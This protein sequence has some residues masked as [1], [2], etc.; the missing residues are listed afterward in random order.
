MN[1]LVKVY[2]TLFTLLM[3]STGVWAQENITYLNYVGG[4]FVSATTPDPAKKITSESNDLSGW[5][6]VEGEVTIN[7]TLDLGG[8]TEIILCDG[9][10]L[11]IHTSIGNGIDLNGHN[12]TIYAQSSGSHKGKLIINSSGYGIEGYANVTIN[13]GNIS[14]NSEGYGISCEN[15]TVNGGAITVVYSGGDGIHANYYVTI[16]GGKIYIENSLYGISGNAGVEINGG[17]V[18]AWGD[19]IG[20]AG[21]YS[22]HD[23]NLGWTNASDYILAN[24]Y[25]GVDYLSTQDGKG[26]NIQ[27]GGTLAGNTNL[28]ADQKNAI[29]YNKLTPNTTTLSYDINVSVGITGGTIEVDKTKAFAGE[30]VAITITPETGKMLTSLT[31]NDGTNTYTIGTN[32]TD[33]KRQAND[34]VITMPNKNVT[35]T[36]TF[37]TIVAKIGT[38]EYA[39]LDDAF[40]AVG[41]GET[42]DIFA[43]TDESA[44][45]HTPAYWNLDFV[46]DLHGHDVKFGHISNSG[47][48]LTIKSTETGGKFLYSSLYDNNG[49]ITIDNVTMTCTG[50]ISSISNV[51]IK[52]STVTLDEVNNPN[53]NLNETFLVDGSTVVCK[54]FSWMAK[55][56]ELK[57]GANVEITNSFQLGSGD[58]GITFT[59]DK[60]ED[61]GSSVFTLTNC[62]VRNGYGQETLVKSQMEQYVQPGK[63]IVVDGSTKN[64]MILKKEWGMMFVNCLP[65]SPVKTAT[66][67]AYKSATEPTEDFISA[68]G[69]VTTEF[70]ANEYVVVHIVPEYGFWTDAQLLMATETGASLAPKRAPGLELGRPLKLLKADEGRNDGAGWYYY[71]IPAT[72]TAAAGYLTTQLDGFVPTK[73]MFN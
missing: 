9:A 57:N 38:M 15:L 30:R 26:F 33:I 37:A 16:N 66:V 49:N 63:T 12:L 17:Q 64:S 10:T 21:I 7:R 23:I 19:V 41:D 22:Y 58:D 36:A 32:S 8:N 28:D 68:P 39:S 44:T 70:N 45:N 72:H 53:G 24:S 59:I 6:Y 62:T 1:K 2:F 40:S 34:Y 27:G 3:S 43:D 13:G 14:L 55:H 71:Q 65:D 73:F 18:S 60:L 29:A 47:S 56:I 51:T 4:T 35:I 61:P 48:D 54:D 46:I 11:T 25:D 42:I 31:Y 52:N 69:D 5:Y 67:T 50:C 20:F